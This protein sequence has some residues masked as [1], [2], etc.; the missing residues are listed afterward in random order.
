MKDDYKD[1]FKRHFDAHEDDINPQLIWENIKPKKKERALWMFLFPFL[2]VLGM[3]SLYLINNPTANELN[4]ENTDLKFGQIP[5]EELHASTEVITNN[6]QS[7]AANN[8]HQSSKEN[9]LVQNSINRNEK[10]A[11]NLLRPREKNN[12]TEVKKS[13][14]KVVFVDNNTKLDSN[15]LVEQVK[16]EKFKS[17]DSNKI[18]T[19]SIAIA[20]LDQL[21]DHWI[22]ELELKPKEKESMF[23][24]LSAGGG[25]SVEVK[26]AISPKW[27]LATVGS[28]GIMSIARKGD[29]E[30]VALR[31]ETLSDLEAIRSNLF[32]NFHLSNRISLS[33]GLQYTRLNE[34]FE[35]QGEYLQSKNG[36]YISEI[37]ITP[38]GTVNN[39]SEGE[40][41]ERV[42]RNMKIYNKTNLISV[43]LKLNLH[44][45]L[46]GIVISLSGGVEA[47][48]FNWNEGFTLNKQGIPIDLGKQEDIQFGINYTA[49]LGFEYL[50]TRHLAVSANLGLTTISSK[51]P[52][53]TSDYQLTEMGL[54]IR[55]FID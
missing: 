53:L 40:Y 52:N 43:P 13:P 28:Y 2:L 7:L 19:K 9:E 21:E 38:E 49:G 1:I 6:T 4:N 44:Q 26:S 18:G 3:V 23:L 33:T 10:F 47:N 30:Y 45:S 39:F 42:S 32:L 5:S 27:S 37:V 54:G 29:E 16:Q 22:I 35:W 34:L 36:Q 50:V 41:K 25:K 20:K 12:F 51:E 31:N 46:G 8:N 14:T 55:Y 11:N 48:V 15:L 24:N 17:L